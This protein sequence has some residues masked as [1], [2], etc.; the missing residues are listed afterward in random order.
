MKDTLIKDSKTIKFHLFVLICIVASIMTT[1]CTGKRSVKGLKAI[2]V[3]EGSLASNLR[4]LETIKPHLVELDVEFDNLPH[5][6]VLGRDYFNAQEINEIEGLLFRFLA[7]QTTLWDMVN[8]YG[9]LGADF[10]ADELDTKA[11]VLSISAT[12]LMASHTS[13][14][15]ARFADDPLAIAQLNETYFRSEIPFGSYD[16]MRENATLP[17]LL[18]STSKIKT[19]YAREMANPQSALATLA[20]NDAEYAKIISQIPSLQET[21]E[22]RL[23]EVARLYP[24]HTNTEK[25]AREDVGQQ[26]KTLYAIRSFLF[27]EVSRLKNPAGHVVVFSDA[28]KQMIF[29]LLE[30]GDLILTYTAGYMSDV[31]IP[32]AFKHGITYIGT[33]ENRESIGLSA[34]GLPSNERFDI[35]KLAANLQRSSLP[36]GKQADMIEAVAE[37]VIFN[38]LEH[39]MDTHINRMLVL[40]PRLSDTERAAFLVEVFSYLGDGYDFRFDFAD[41]SMQVCTEVIY[42]AINGKGSIDF[43][44]TERAGHETL[45][46]DDIANYYQDSEAFDFVLLA[47]T[48]PASKNNEA[49][50]LVGSEGELRVK[51]LMNA[52]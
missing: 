23:Q 6:G 30:P 37:G 11:H 22:T 47:E 35:Q 5:P 1:G 10:S 48:D 45:S 41:A 16:H 24:S 25:L 2:A 19:L 15:V 28:Q 9:G 51:A 27:K 52:R 7:L 4:I 34:N 50:L 13:F 20:N 3:T 36:D 33:P 12:L 14:I 46:A 38:D 17:N 43:V 26:H 8:S 21:S 40:R 49:L 44:L 31:F 18:E 42:R 39:I 32:G 29:S